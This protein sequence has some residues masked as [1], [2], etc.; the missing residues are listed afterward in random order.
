MAT[1]HP[2]VKGQKACGYCVKQRSL[3]CL[4]IP[5]LNLPNRVSSDFTLC[6]STTIM[7]YSVVDI[8]A[9]ITCQIYMEL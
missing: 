5:W 1:L 3:M 7:T 4:E 6:R 2:T 8:K 9:D